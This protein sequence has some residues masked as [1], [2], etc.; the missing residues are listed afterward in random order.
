MK[1]QTSHLNYKIELSKTAQPI[2]DSQFQNLKGKMPE[3]EA[4]LLAVRATLGK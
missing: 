2:F 1:I 3:R 4:F